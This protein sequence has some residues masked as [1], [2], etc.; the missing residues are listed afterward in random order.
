M[1]AVLRRCLTILLYKPLDPVQLSQ[2]SL[3]NCIYFNPWVAEPFSKWGGTS[4]RQKN[5]RKFLWFELATVTSQALKY[6]VI[7]YTVCNT[8]YEG[9][10]YTILDKN[11]T[12]KKTYR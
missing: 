9:Q 11:Y 10:N 4:A 6:D 1:N 3:R 2:M 5:D 7:A 8:P 12:T